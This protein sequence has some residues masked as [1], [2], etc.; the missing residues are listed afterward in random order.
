MVGKVPDTFK[1]AAP[2]GT[3]DA[4]STVE[5]TAVT[6]SSRVLIR[7]AFAIPAAPLPSPSLSTRQSSTTGPDV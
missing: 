2:A 3:C 5:T 1:V 6:V 4:T 7:L